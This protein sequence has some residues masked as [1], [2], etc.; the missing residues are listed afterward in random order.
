LRIGVAATQSTIIDILAQAGDEEVAKRLRPLLE[1]S[2]DRIETFFGK[3][4]EKPITVEIVPDRKAFNDY[5]RK[6]WNLPGTER[7]MVALGVADRM[8]VLS[9]RVWKTEAVEHDPDDDQHM[10][11]LLAHELVH[12]YHGQRSPR[13]DFDGMDDLGWFVEGVAVYA[14]GQLESAHR[15]RA[16]ESIAA[17]KAPTC[18]ANAWSGA[19]RYGVAGSMV[20]FIDHR[21]GREMIRKLLS[22]VSNEEALNLLGTT[23]SR[24]LADWKAEVPAVP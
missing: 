21:H 7:W 13:P 20:Q 17:G 1:S 16:A 6:R 14:S 12:V 10:R 23:E 3:R 2:R 22:A 5:V 19:Y 18:L 24:F 15:N 11:L 9:P 8:L 4:F